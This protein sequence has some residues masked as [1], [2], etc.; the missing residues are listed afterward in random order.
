MNK[1]EILT[2]LIIRQKKLLASFNLTENKDL[3]IPVIKIAEEINL[4]K[5]DFKCQHPYCNSTTELQF[6]HLIN[7]KYKDYMPFTQYACQ[8]HY[9]A[10]I[11]ILCIKHH[12]QIE[13]RVYPR[14]KNYHENGVISEE[15]IN[16]VK[17]MIKDANS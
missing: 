6:H 8:R 4:I 2:G 1:E 16:E 11:I 7:R 13:G 9:W 14:S 17:E 10:N 3:L 15:R 5:A 12:A